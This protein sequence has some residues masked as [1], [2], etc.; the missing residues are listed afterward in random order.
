MVAFILG[1]VI[2]ALISWLSFF[3]AV[4]PF[5]KKQATENVMLRDAVDSW[6]NETHYLEGILQEYEPWRRGES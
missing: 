5:Y 6:Q 4:Y 3:V 2:G 1:A